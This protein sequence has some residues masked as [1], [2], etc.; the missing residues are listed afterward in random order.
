MNSTEFE[1]RLRVMEAYHNL[2]VLPDLF[3]VIRVDGRSFS[4]FTQDNY[5]KPF[6]EHFRD[7]MVET[8]KTL[9][10]QLGG[11]FVYTESDEISLFL[12]KD[13]DVFGR[14]VEKLVST[15]AAIASSIFT[16]MYL[17]LNP[18]PKNP[19]TFDSRLIVLPSEQWVEDYARWRMSDAGRCAL[20]GWAYWTLRKEGMSKRK[21]TSMIERGMFSNVDHDQKMVNVPQKGVYNPEILES[22]ESAAWKNELLFQRGINF[23]H[24]PTWQR[25]GVGI[26]WKEYEKQGYN[27]KTQETVTALRRAPHVDLELPWK[28]DYGVFLR[29][30]LRDGAVKVNEDPAASS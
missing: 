11:Y 8:A 21:A 18:P 25:R 4:R 24:L 22:S 15:S 13:Y 16:T 27:P 19:I 5:E 12:P 26:Y 29:K 1:A 9:L 10:E 28:D 14:S 23:A 20:N 3:T 6:D 7:L 30:L 17:H 2:S